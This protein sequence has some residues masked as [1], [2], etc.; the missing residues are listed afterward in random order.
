V[1]RLGEAEEGEREKDRGNQ[2]TMRDPEGPIKA[3]RREKGRL[4]QN[5]KRPAAEQVAG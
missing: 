1:A 4:R 5:G 2:E 3:G